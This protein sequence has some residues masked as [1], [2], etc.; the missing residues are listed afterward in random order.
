MHPFKGVD[1]NAPE[2]SKVEQKIQ[3]LVTAGKLDEA[4]AVFENL[5]PH[6]VLTP[7]VIAQMQAAVKAEE[8]G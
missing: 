7:E 1:I 4:R 8:L 5:D 3:A 6:T 2:L